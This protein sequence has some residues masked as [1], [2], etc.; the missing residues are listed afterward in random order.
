MP[1]RKKGDKYQ[2]VEGIDTLSTLLLHFSSGESSTPMYKRKGALLLLF[3][4]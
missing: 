1:T 2:K 3:L 4:G